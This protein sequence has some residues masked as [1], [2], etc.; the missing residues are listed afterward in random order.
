MNLAAKIA[1]PRLVY[2]RAEINRRAACNSRF[3][4]FPINFSGYPPF[5]YSLSGM[6][7]SRMSWTMTRLV[8]AT[9]MLV[10]RRGAKT[11]DQSGSSCFGA[12]REAARNRAA[13]RRRARTIGSEGHD[14]TGNITARCGG[15]RL[16]SGLF[17]GAEPAAEDDGSRTGPAVRAPA[18]RAGGAFDAVGEPGGNRQAQGRR[19]PAR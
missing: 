6:S 4:T 19:G 15:T 12:A 13:F 7:A 14:S 1:S 8:S 17:A 3:G 2:W 10:W 11:L 5:R 9:T 18:H 16:H